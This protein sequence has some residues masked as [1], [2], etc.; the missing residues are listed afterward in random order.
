MSKPT[1]PIHPV[2]K[3]RKIIG[4]SQT[5]FASMVG[6]TKHTI[7]SV[8]NERNQ[9]SRNLAKR[10]E[11]ATGANL[12]DGKAESYTRADFDYWREKYSQ[13]NKA[14]ALKQFEDMKVWLRVVFLAAA[15]SGR[16]GNRDRLP[17][18][19]LSLAEWLNEAREK[20]K[21]EDEIEDVLDDETR[22]ISTSGRPISSLLEEPEQSKKDLAEYDI[23]FDQIRKELKK[24]TK[25]GFLIIQ[26]EVRR[27][28]TPG[29]FSHSVPG[30]PRTLIP[31][32][33]VWI[34]EFKGSL[35]NLLKS[36]YS[37]PD[38]YKYLKRVGADSEFAEQEFKRNALKS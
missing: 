3:L 20:F 4:K 13:T 30:R 12:L 35:E 15:K 5:Q 36:G 38:F 29:T 37:H 10:I 11:I 21:L 7:I 27:V 18:V 34:K 16:A 19:S 22:D 9:L 2:A 8:E 25:D 31:K 23:S 6:V 32:A 17:A 33:R 24:N 14:A 26:D 1:K 28:W